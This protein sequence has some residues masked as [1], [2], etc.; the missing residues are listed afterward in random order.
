MNRSQTSPLFA[1][2]CTCL[3]GLEFLFLDLVHG[4][5]EFAVTLGSQISDVWTELHGTIDHRDFVPFAAVLWIFRYGIVFA[6][7]VWHSLPHFRFELER[8]DRDEHDHLEPLGDLT[9][10]V[11]VFMPVPETAA[12]NVFRVVA[13]T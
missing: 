3:H 5:G 2:S 4:N 1:M 8:I 6:D 10:R 9:E 13:D 7:Q 12:H 11:F